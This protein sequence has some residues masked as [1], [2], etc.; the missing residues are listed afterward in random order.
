MHTFED[1]RH[2]LETLFEEKYQPERDFIDYL[3]IKKER[4]YED[5]QQSSDK[6][7]STSAKGEMTKKRNSPPSDDQDLMPMD[8][9]EDH[10]LPSAL[11]Q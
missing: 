6:S 10:N 4:S 3:N 11:S 9:D 1:C 7:K 5:Y 8:L 2:R